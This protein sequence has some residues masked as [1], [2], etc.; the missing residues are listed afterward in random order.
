MAVS[1][2]EI[3][4]E[5]VEIAYVPGIV[6]L[7]MLRDALRKAADTQAPDAFAQALG[8]FG[9]VDRDFRAKIRNE[10]IALAE[11]RRH[12]NVSG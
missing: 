5:A 3:L 7:R 4:A 12:V 11:I 2:L 10:A 9:R 8:A 6:E 1:S